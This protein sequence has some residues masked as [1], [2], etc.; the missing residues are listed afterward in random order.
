[1]TPLTVRYSLL[2][3][4]MPGEGNIVA[5]P[6]LSDDGQCGPVPLDGSPVIDAGDT[7]ALPSDSADFDQDGGTP[8]RLPLD[9]PGR[10]RAR[11][12]PETADSGVGPAPVV[13][14]GA[15]EFRRKYGDLDHNG[16]VELQD[17]AILL[18]SFGSAGGDLDGDGDT[19]LADLALL[20]SS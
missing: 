15:F 9:L 13:D 19:D 11:D 3:A 18:A 10:A 1:S 5:N 12:D 7:T 20:L 2:R 6:M 16:N 14:I 4:L 17:L 8:E